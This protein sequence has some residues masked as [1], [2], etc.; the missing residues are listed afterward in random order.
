MKKLL[1]ILLLGLFSLKNYAAHV[2]G[3]EMVYEYLGAGSTANS[4]SYRITLKLFKDNTSG[5]ALP[6]SVSI[7]IYDGNTLIG[8]Y[9]TAN[10]DI[11]GGTQLVINAFPTCLSNPPTLNYA[12]GNYTFTTDLPNNNNGYT[13]SYQTC[14]RIASDITNGL[15]NVNSPST[16]GAGS[17][18]SAVIPG[19]VS[20]PISQNNSSPKFSINV[21]V[22]CY[23]N[24]FTFNF[25]ATD[26]DGDSLSYAFCDAYGGGAATGSTYATP[27]APPYAS[28]NYI[29]PYTAAVPMGNT[30]SINQ[31]TGVISGIAPSTLG[32]YV[33]SVCASE[34]RDGM[35]IGIHQKDFIVQVND[36][37]I[38]QALLNFETVTCDGFTHTFFNA[39]TNGGVITSYFWDFGVP[40]ILSDTSRLQNPTYTFPDTGIF[41]I[42]LV[43][44]RGQ[45]CSDSTTRPFGIYPGFFPNFNYVGVCYTS[46][47]QFV[48]SSK[49]NFGF[50]NSWS[51]DF[52][53][54]PVL[55][56]TSHLQNPTYTYPSA[57]NYDV[58]L[59]IT[60]SKGCI[61][62]VLKNIVLIDKP[63]I[64][65]P[66]KDTLICSIDTLQLQSSFTS[67][68]PSWLPNYRIINANTNNPLVYP[69]V[70]TQYIVT[71]ND[72]GCIQ[73][74][75][76]FVRVK[77]FVTIDVMADTTICLTDNFKIR[78]TTDALTFM[79]TPSATLSSSSIKEPIATP[80]G[81]PTKYVVTANIGKCQARDSITVTAFPYPTVDAG[82]DV[83]ICSGFSTVLNGTVTGNSFV[84]SPISTLTNAN[85]LTPTA[86]PLT[87]TSYILST[88]NTTGCKK[89]AKDTVKV[90]VIPPIKAFAGAD[91]VI[92]VGQPLQLQGTG[93]TNYIWTPNNFLSNNVISNPI[94][95]LSNNQTYYLRV[96][97]TN[98][99]FALDTI[100]IVVFKTEP[101]IFV[102]T[103]F[104]PNSDGRNDIMLPVA[105]GLKQYDYFEVYNR[106]GQLMYKSTKIG[107][108]WDGKFK[109]EPQ[110]NQ[111]FVWQVQG[112]DYKGKKIFKKGTVILIR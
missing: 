101:D 5:A 77:D 78:N 71:A 50:V 7:G 112:I 40:G 57:G 12:V 38:P 35:L 54:T 32:R 52:G 30:V 102:P 43:V 41:I 80:T 55:N 98:G 109:G 2:I 105:V 85:T 39:S 15:V 79:W 63:S 83:I 87:T 8:G 76:V 46:P 90:I 110:D 16:G 25:G 45:P 24:A 20:L 64:T 95:T 11:T 75:T 29:N 69:L 107:E 53:N 74:D 51:W 84:W 100:N 88:T 9:R 104:T 33:I 61:D 18:Y 27:A 56:D 21:S 28:V 23:N 36:C 3:G 73:K 106:W 89:P 94:A 49:T 111:T 22:I 82:P 58:Q 34:F 68:N 59:I 70:T 60:N 108:G 17:T 62:T 14:C 103:A 67:G 4:K 48:D 91:T 97:D 66:F 92:V 6:N 81:S 93:G 96:S 72:Q 37:A 26:A 99:C 42:K 19:V 86:K 65:L 13:I 10:I 1:L 47:I 31:N 44:N